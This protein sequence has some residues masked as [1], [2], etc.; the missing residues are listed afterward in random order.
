MPQ[1]RDW[2][3]EIRAFAQGLGHSDSSA[4]AVPQ[5]ARAQQRE[6]N[7]GELFISDGHPPS[8]V[9]PPTL[10]AVRWCTMHRNRAKRRTRDTLQPSS[11]LH[12]RGNEAARSTRGAGQADPPEVEGNIETRPKDQGLPNNCFPLW[13]GPSSPILRLPLQAPRVPRRVLMSVPL[14]STKAEAA[15]ANIGWNM[16]HV[17]NRRRCS[18][19]SSHSCLIA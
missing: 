5:L 7:S 19:S 8:P 16:E 18:S 4:A 11:E 13:L 6:I 9:P 12:G 17:P 3:A 10:S 15:N 2:R 1:S 14:D